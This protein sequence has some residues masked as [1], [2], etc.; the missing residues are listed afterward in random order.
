V[1][2]AE[3][4]LAARRDQDVEA[5]VGAVL[6]D[7]LGEQDGDHNRPAVFHRARDLFRLITRG[8]YRLD[9]EEGDDAAFRAYDT[10]THQG[11][12]LDELSS[13]TRLQLLLAV[14]LAF[15][16]TQETGAA[17]PLLLDEVLANCDDDRATAIIDAALAIAR[18][19]RQIF[20]FTA[21]ADELAKW[22][23]RLQDQDD[24]EWSVQGV[25][26][27]DGAT[28]AAMAWTPPPRHQ[29]PAPDGMDHATY[30]QA[31]RVPPF[32]PWAEG[33]GGLHLWYL[34][35]DVHALHQ[36][37]AMGI[38]RW[39]QLDHLDAAGGQNALPGGMRDVV[40]QARRTA[41]LCD[42][43]RQLWRQGRGR[44]VD[45]AALLESGAI[46]HAFMDAV[47]DL[48]HELEGRGEAL[49]DALVDRRLP[50]F[51]TAKAEEL[52]AF[53]QDRGYLSEDVPLPAD[54]IRVRLAAEAGCMATGERVLARLMGPP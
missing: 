26:D 11:H 54:E 30:G 16:E 13:G 24:V 22:R 31:L 25:L 46:S 17:L 44:P 14:R 5:Q 48:C 9:M 18:E 38:S 53:L 39:G 43:F 42:R 19:G 4:D 27:G 49:I 1:A 33:V 6:V 23:D 2:E 29:V 28:A 50:R 12:A 35:D 45:R 41:A 51:Q 37:L 52:R 7:W 47:A 40:D 10:T 8:R 20:Y 15:V 36:L 32:D 34:V 3:A 21:Q